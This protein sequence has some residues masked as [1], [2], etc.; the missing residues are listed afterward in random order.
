MYRY[1]HTDTYI[2]HVNLP[3]T[4]IL[5]F[6][7]GPGA[8][9]PSQETTTPETISPQP[10]AARPSQ[11]CVLYPPPSRHSRVLYPPPPRHSHS[12]VQATAQQYSYERLSAKKPPSYKVFS[13][14]NIFC[15][16]WCGLYALKHSNQVRLPC[17][18]NIIIYLSTVPI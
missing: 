5:T 15:C 13:I 10:P 4:F 8:I 16:L 1:V 3:I 11:S 9:E 17:Y 18:Y 7:P 2:L 14:L 6:Y 12:Q